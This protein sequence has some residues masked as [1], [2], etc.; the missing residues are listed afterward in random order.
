MTM[1]DDVILV[2]E[3]DREIGTMEKLEAHRRG[4][5][6]RAF[7]I[8]LFSPDGQCLLQRRAAG[9]YHSGGLWS[10]ACCSHPRPGEDMAAATARRLEEEIGVRCPLRKVLEIAYD[11]DVGGGMREAEYNHTYLGVLDA[12]VPLTPAP[13][14]CSACQWRPVAEIERELATAPEAYSPWF[15]LLFP[16]VLAAR[17]P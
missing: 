14:E 10:N 17:S 6:H 13:E 11:L 9:K 4:L 15:V 3:A 12:G 7:S 2:D 5:L 16:K 8:F 1:T